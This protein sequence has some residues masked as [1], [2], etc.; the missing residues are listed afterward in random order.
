MRITENCWAFPSLADALT[1][2]SGIGTS[3]CFSPCR[4]LHV[5]VSA[6]IHAALDARRRTGDCTAG[7]FCFRPAGGV[8]L[9]CG[10][11]ARCCGSGVDHQPS[12]GPALPPLAII[13][14]VLYALGYFVRLAV[15]L[16]RKD[17][18][19]MPPRDISWKKSW[20]PS[21]WRWPRLR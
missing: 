17:R 6:S 13:T 10:V 18:D 16:N 11:A 7:R 3:C 15:L 5:S 20:S 9:V 2:L 21:L 14:V 8:V 19:P 1:L 12:R 4:F